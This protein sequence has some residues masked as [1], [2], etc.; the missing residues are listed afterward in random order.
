M[1][2]NEEASWNWKEKKD[3]RQDVQLPIFTQTL[4]I[5]RNKNDFEEIEPVTP[6]TSPISPVPW[7]N[8]SPSSSSSLISPQKRGFKSLQEVYEQCESCQLEVIK[9]THFEEAVQLEEWRHA[10]KEELRMIEKNQT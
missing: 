8:A 5:Q 10:M 7:R 9:P 2:F 1:I 6:D 3:E 4:Q